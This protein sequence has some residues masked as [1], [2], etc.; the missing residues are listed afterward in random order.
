VY[1]CSV[2]R[3]IIHDVDFQNVPITGLN[4]RPGILMIEVFCIIEVLSIRIQ[5]PVARSE[6]VLAH[7]ALRAE[8]FVVRIDVKLAHGRIFQRARPI[9]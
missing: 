3:E 7:N 6:R 5:V 4:L 9:G 8:R 2:V 1:R